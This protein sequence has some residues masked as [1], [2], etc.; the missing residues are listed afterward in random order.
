MHYLLPV[1]WKLSIAPVKVNIDLKFHF[2]LHVMALS[3]PLVPCGAA[4]MLAGEYSC[5][6]E[7]NCTT[8]CE[9]MEMCPCNVC[10]NTCKYKVH[11]DEVHVGYNKLRYRLIVVNYSFVY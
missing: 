6:D 2:I 9:G 10:Q 8:C 11:A 1:F 3:H 7:Q 5:H 4:E